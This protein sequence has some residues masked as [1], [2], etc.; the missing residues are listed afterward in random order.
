MPGRADQG[1][2]RPGALRSSAAPRSC[3]QLAH[4][5]V[6]GDPVL[7]VLETGV[8]GVEHLAGA[9]RVESLLGALGPGHGDQPVEVGADHRGL[10][11]GIAHP[12]QAR[13]LLLGLLADLVGHPGLLDLGAVL[14]DDRGVVLAQLLA[15]RLH[16]LAQEVLAL[17]LLGAG[18]DVVADPGADLELGEP[19]ALELQRQLEALGDVKRLEQLALLG[20]AEVGRV[21]RGVGQL[22]GLRDRAQ[23]GA[24][25]V[26]GAAQLE[27]LL[28]HGAVLALQL[29]DPLAARLVVG[30]RGDLDPQI[31]GAVGAGVLGGAAVEA[32]HGDRLA[33]ARHPHPL[34]HLGHHADRG[35]LAIGAGHQKDALLLAHVERE[36]RGHAREDQDVFERERAAGFPSQSL[37]SL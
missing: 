24:D 35:E 8:V 30:M 3:A 37:S 13:E 33:A 23:E 11:G 21:G 32:L 10:A 22:A 6:L 16:L 17:L 36:R 7:D 20:L 15:D 26:V 14:V 25:A 1:E 12:L 34:E 31:A 9:G 18:L 19:L 27:D 4:R 2:D 29:L 28:D 5:D